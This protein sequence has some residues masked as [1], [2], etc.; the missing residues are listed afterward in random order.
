MKL[1]ALGA[2]SSL[3]AAMA[4]AP[5]SVAETIALATVSTADTAKLDAITRQTFDGII[6]GKAHEALD[7]FFGSS[8]LMRS[9]AGELRMLA[10][11]IDS[12]GGLYGAMG[13][14]RLSEERI[15][16]GLVVQRLYL[17]RHGQYMTR[18]K[19]MFAN[20][21]NGWTGANISY[22]DKVWLGLDD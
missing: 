21:S 6:N 18:W 2:V 15:R 12:L 10:N 11:Q 5:P 4:A 13:E 7:G 22:D 19:L 8:E 17:C 20:T 16:A 1:W 9:K 14:C 3:I